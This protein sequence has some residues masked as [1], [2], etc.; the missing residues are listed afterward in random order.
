MYEIWIKFKDYGEF[1]HTIYTEIVY[2]SRT[3]FPGE[4]CDFRGKSYGAF[5]KLS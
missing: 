5:M 4:Y 3:I 1:D 2:M